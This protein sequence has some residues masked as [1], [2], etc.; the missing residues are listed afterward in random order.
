VKV[1]LW[2]VR[3][4]EREVQV[5]P[6]AGTYWRGSCLFCWSFVL[7]VKGLIDYVVGNVDRLTY[8]ADHAVL[9]RLVGGLVEFCPARDAYQ[10]VL[11]GWGSTGIRVRHVRVISD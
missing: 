4:W 11:V 2:V 3:S 5:W 9:K 8:I 6:W 1:F 7:L 10:V